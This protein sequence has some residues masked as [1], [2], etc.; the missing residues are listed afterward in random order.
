MAARP[1]VPRRNAAAREASR[2][3]ARAGS[4]L[5]FMAMIPDDDLDKMKRSIDLAAVIR[6]R[7]IDLKPQGHDLVGLCPFHDDKHP[8]LHVT[9]AKGLWRCVSCQA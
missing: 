3:E 9:P 2:G 4:P 1:S 8:S 6:S 7:G 5:K